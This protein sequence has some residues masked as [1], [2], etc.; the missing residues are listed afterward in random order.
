MDIMN[1]MTI[2]NFSDCIHCDKWAWCSMMP[3]E[4]IADPI[5][6]DEEGDVNGENYSSVAK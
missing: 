4:C 5:E 2:A 1:P 6:F 3:D